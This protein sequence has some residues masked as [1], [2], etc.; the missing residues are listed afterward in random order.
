[1]K[2]CPF[3][4]L[5]KHWSPE[6]LAEIET[7]VGSALAELDQK[8]LEQTTEQKPFQAVTRKGSDARKR[9]APTRSL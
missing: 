7:R 5:T 2:H 4:E 3:S 8:E 9:A 6:R 1:M